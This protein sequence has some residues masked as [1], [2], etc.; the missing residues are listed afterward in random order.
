MFCS[1]LIK[2]NV[3]NQDMK[4]T[5]R[6]IT[7]CSGFDAQL[8]GLKRLKQYAQSIGEDIEVE[9]VAWS[10]FDPESNRP[11]EEQPAVVAHKMLHPECA[12]RNLGDM[13]KIDWLKFKAELMQGRIPIRNEEFANLYTTARNYEEYL[14]H[15]TMLSD[16]GKK[17]VNWDANIDIL[18]YSTPCLTA[19]MRC[20]T[21]EG[22]KPI[23]DIKVGEKV[24]TKGNTWERVAKKFDNGRHETC[25][26]DVLGI[27]NPI[28]CTYNHKFYV[29]REEIDEP[30]FI[31]AKDLKLG[32]SLLMVRSLNDV[33]RGANWNLHCHNV[34]YECYSFLGVRNGDVENVYNMEVE[35]DHSYIVEG[36][37]SK[38]CQ[39]ISNAGLQHGFEPGSGT[40]SSILWDTLKCIEVMRPKY[41]L[42]E[43][44]AAI[45]SEK[46]LPMFNA[47]Q[48]AVEK[49]GYRN[50]TQLM[51]A[52]E[53]GVP[54]NR[55]RLFMLSV[56]DDLELQ[57]KFPTPFKIEKTLED[58][59]E[60]KVGG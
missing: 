20:L 29:K 48:L 4:K 16:L 17:V 45:V 42:Q 52:K 53:Y 32:D 10:E 56:R 25:Y 7:I 3:K 8:L 54:Q 12:D 15:P 33:E 60:K 39:S 22:Y 9:C 2:L 36:V 21:E 49:L 35:N 46:F 34:Y 27:A 11:N 14:D 47:W 19:D 30:L 38:N 51:N 55:N 41:L 18:T 24:L 37:V 26:V 13:T 50:Y 43:N 1:I 6:I 57:Y 28:H 5:A 40:R 23:I 44:V 59:L 58:V 31:E